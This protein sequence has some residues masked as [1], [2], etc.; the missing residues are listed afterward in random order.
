MSSQL[1]SEQIIAKVK[2][3]IKDA[4]KDQGDTINFDNVT[5]STDVRTLGLD[6]L[7][8]IS[9]RFNLDQAL[10]VDI[11]DDDFEEKEL[12]VIKNLIEYVQTTAT[13]CE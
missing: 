7:D 2:A 11:S 12:T 6:S 10:G 13:V 1:S 3:V 4:T 5:E 8:M 9:Y